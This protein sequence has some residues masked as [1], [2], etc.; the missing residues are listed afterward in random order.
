MSLILVILLFFILSPPLQAAEPLDV[1]I[2]EIAWMGTKASSNDEWIELY[3]NTNYNI[4]LNGWGIY[5][6]ETL[7]VALTNI[8]E[9]HSYYLVERTDNTTVK[10]IEASQEP[11]GWG[12]YG[13]NNKGEN[14]KLLNQELK[15]ID[16]ID[17]TSGWFAGIKESY[18]T[19]ERIIL[20]GLGSD[21]NNWH[22]NTLSN[23]A[24]DSDNNFIQGTPKSV[25]SSVEIQIQEQIIYSSNISINELL[26][27]S[28][29]SDSENEWIELKNNSN[30][31][32]VLS[33][34]KIRDIEGR[35]KTYNFPEETIILAND[36][37]ILNRPET[38]ITLNNDKDGLE[39]I[40]PNDEVVSSVSY[41]NALKEES[42]AF[43]EK[44]WHWTRKLTPGEENIVFQNP[45]QND[46]NQV[47]SINH[48]EFGP[49]KDNFFVVLIKG[50]LTATLFSL[51][52]IRLKKTKIN[53]IFKKK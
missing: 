20:Q 27:Y 16:E 18:K 53:L 6:E 13:L 32:V 10:N 5:E 36:F 26:P 22:S 11:V 51:I 9:P 44:E 50:C 35:T 38:K 39:L 30:E 2:S 17:C 48:K 24:L 8:I 33:N 52:A 21:P 45:V 40:N 37:L 12:G 43:W 41:T 1:V 23:Q 46:K 7:I 49:K 3:N 4:D 31:D 19:M 29:E 28:Q 25:N 47:I 14:L 34:W 42:Y 15:I